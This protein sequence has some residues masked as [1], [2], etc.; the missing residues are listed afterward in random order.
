MNIHSDRYKLWLLMKTL[1]DISSAWRL[2]TYP[3]GATSLML[4]IQTGD[5]GITTTHKDKYSTFATTL[6]LSRLFTT[7]ELNWRRVYAQMF[8]KKPPTC[9]QIDALYKL[10]D[11]SITLPTALAILEH[12]MNDKINPANMRYFLQEMRCDT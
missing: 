6:I 10:G 12:E 2:R 11:R 8:Y 4:Y 5:F 9:P 7:N 3:Y 1:P